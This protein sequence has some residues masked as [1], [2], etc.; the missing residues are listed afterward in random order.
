MVM[1]F[2]RQPPETNNSRVCLK[3]EKPPKMTVLV[4]C[5]FKNQPKRG[6]TVFRNPALKFGSVFD[7]FPITTNQQWGPPFRRGWFKGKPKGHPSCLG[8]PVL[9]H[10]RIY[11]YI[12]IYG[13]HCSSA[14]KSCQGP[15]KGMA[16]AHEQPQLLLIHTSAAL[17]LQKLPS[18]DRHHVDGCEIPRNETVGNR[19]SVANSAPLLKVNNF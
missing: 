1:V 9:A 2:R 6:S 14:T 7:A 12:Y 5:S 8:S 3:I 17:K 4:W 15:G 11:I 13:H 16:H 19:G 18:S 10:T